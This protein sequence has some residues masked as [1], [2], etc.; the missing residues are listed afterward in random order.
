[1][2]AGIAAGLLA[3]VGV[4]APIVIFSADTSPGENIGFAAVLVLPAVTFA[5]LG[6]VIGTMTSSLLRRKR[7]KIT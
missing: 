3:Y 2:P 1:M 7:S 4:L 6:A 5:A